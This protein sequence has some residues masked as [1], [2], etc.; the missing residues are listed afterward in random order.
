MDNNA[1]VLIVTGLPRSG[2]SMCMKML[3]AGGY[4]VLT[5]GLRKP[6]EDNPNGYYEYEAVKS[7]HQDDNWLSQAR[8]KAVKMVYRLL[9]DLPLDR[10]IERN[11][12]RRSQI[13]YQQGRR[14][15]MALEDDIKF[16]VRDGLR[17]LELIRVQYPIS[18]TQ[19]ALAAEQVISTRLQLALGIEGVRYTDLLLALQSSRESLRSV[20]FARIGY[21]V[22]RAQFVLDL[23]LMQFNV[24]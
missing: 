20:A 10:R 22:Q 7:T 23:E 19:A 13:N 1:K 16:E 4:P 21:L 11:Q 12:Y 9:Y 3:E 17:S 14:D 18:V 24:E 2:T 6:D 5:D 8:G 15:L